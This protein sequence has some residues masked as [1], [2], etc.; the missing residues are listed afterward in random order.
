M[1]TARPTAIIYDAPD[2]SN[3]SHLFS[4][5]YIFQTN[6]SKELPYSFA[7]GNNDILSVRQLE[8]DYMNWHSRRLWLFYLYCLFNGF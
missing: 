2:R 4:W 3:N 6:T 7:S 8:F 1:P 5:N